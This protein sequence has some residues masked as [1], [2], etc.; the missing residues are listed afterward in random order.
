MRKISADYF[1]FTTFALPSKPALNAFFPI[2][3]FI[4]SYAFSCKTM[5][6]FV[7]IRYD[8]LLHFCSEFLQ[9]GVLFVVLQKNLS[10]MMNV[11]RRSR[12]LS[13]TQFS[14]ELGLSRSYTQALLN[15]RGNP[16]M[17]TI[18]HI[19]SRLQISPLLLLCCSYSE[20]QLEI[21]LLL[22]ILIRRFSAL[23]SAKQTEFL[24]LFQKLLSLMPAES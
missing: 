18:E 15:G 4:S 22:L 23:S 5:Y 14:E 6:F 9:K 20:E 21:F 16:R 10:V 1:Y 11:I 12:N 13:S 7:K 24:V 2:C 8:R 3:R 17:D 19:A